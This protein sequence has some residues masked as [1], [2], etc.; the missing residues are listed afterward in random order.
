MKKWNVYAAAVLA[1]VGIL[2]GCGAKNAESQAPAETQAAE[3]SAQ[4]SSVEE[5]REA[6]AE[7]SKTETEKKMETLSP[8][9]V[10][11]P[12]NV[13]SIV[14]QDQEIFASVFGPMGYDVQYSDLTTGPG[15]RHR[16]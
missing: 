11:S 10:K 8:S 2:G 6:S 13:P 16:P 1:A 4:E 15:D 9:P 7:E 3:Q 5:S 14:E 12:L